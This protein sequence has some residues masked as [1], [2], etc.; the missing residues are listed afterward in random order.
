MNFFKSIKNNS[1]SGAVLTAGWQAMQQVE[2]RLAAAVQKL[3]PQL[4]QQAV[5]QYT[6]AIRMGKESDAAA[7][8][9]QTVRTQLAEFAKQ[10]QQKPSSFFGNK[11]K[12][13]GVEDFDRDLTPPAQS[14][15]Q[16]PRTF[17]NLSKA[18]PAQ[19]DPQQ[20]FQAVRDKYGAYNGPQEVIFPGQ[21]AAQKELIV[22]N[23]WTIP[24]PEQPQ[25][26]NSN[27]STFSGEQF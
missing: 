6:N 7:M 27:P 2:P 15:A 25:P 19:P 12:P 3:P 24:K 10:P 5:L 14:P 18:Q 22:P 23:N 4:Q 13:Y 17:G 16:Q 11:Q 20:A 26:V 9:T 1:D 21:Q 8:T